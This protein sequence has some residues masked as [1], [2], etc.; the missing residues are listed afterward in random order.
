VLSLLTPGAG[1]VVL[2]YHGIGRP[3]PRGEEHYTLAR[4]DF[5]RH[6]ELLAGS[7]RVAGFEDFIA[8]RAR[9][10]AVVLTFD[11]GERSVVELAL[12]LLRAAGLTAAVFMTTGWIGA[13]GYLSAD[14][15]RALRDEA[16]WSVGTHGV[17]HR[18]LSD[19]SDQQV[20]EELVQSRDALARLLG[21]R[22]PDAATDADR[23][24]HMSLPGGRADRRVIAA[25]RRAG[26]ASLCTSAI[27]LNPTPLDPFGVRRMM[28]LSG[29]STDLL[30]RVIDGDR[31]LYLELQGRQALLGAAKR[32][33]GNK[34]YDRLRA[35]AF[36]LR[37]CR[38]G[39]GSGSSAGEDGR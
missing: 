33:L 37:G 13:E 31:R 5:A 3:A 1:A 20:R 12:P 11:D 27:G 23:P 7:G 4:E 9:P 17:T 19:L 15:L 24:L 14:E 25:A 29:W 16:G 32:A 6:V 18:Y 39:A 28:V 34:L 8:G 36:A 30:R 35:A 38:A 26:Y 10:D 2:M 22:G 21:P